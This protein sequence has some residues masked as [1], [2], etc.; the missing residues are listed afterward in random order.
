MS[1]APHVAKPGRGRWI[2]WVL[3]SSGI[4]AFVVVL[5]RSDV[6]GALSVL[7]HTGPIVVLAFVPYTVQIGFDALAW[8]VLL[9]GLSHRVSWHRLFAV[10]LATEAVL[11]TMPGGSLIG[12]SLKPYLLSRSAQ[13][14]MPATVASIA[15]KRCLLGMAQ[16]IYLA[17]A[18][19]IGSD[20]L[21]RASHSVIG[22]GG[23]PV[24]AAIV[25]GA[26]FAISALLAVVLTG[27]QLSRRIHGGLSR[28]PSRRL[29]AALDRWRGGF[30]DADTG[31]AKL[32]AQRGRLALA[33]VIL[34]GAWLVESI[35][36]YVLLRVVGVDLPITEVVAM[37]ASVVF[38]RNAAFFLPAGL[39]VQDAGYLGFL[40]AFGV[41]TAPASAFVLLKRTKE[42]VWIGIGYLDLFVLDG[43]RHDRDS[44]PSNT[45]ARSIGCSLPERRD[46]AP[47]DDFAFAKSLT[48]I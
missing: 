18:V 37:E 13:V 6:S 25:A 43:R 36:T 24:L 35:E 11:M 39:G 10:R 17:T 32:G 42:L 16:G 4:V 12:E 9:A 28:L 33:G 44:K 19:V 31:L 34:L 22:T 2:R 20:A 48:E 46:T 8:R 7:A 38:A 29:R 21:A 3:W 47:H 15:F 5:A 1:E 14:P 27:S 26:L 30:T 40:S 41:A 23:L 45:V